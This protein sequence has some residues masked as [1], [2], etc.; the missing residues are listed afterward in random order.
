[1]KKLILLL[2]T[3]TYASTNAWPSLSWPTM[4]FAN[5]LPTFNF[6]RNGQGLTQ[7][8][9]QYSDIV[10]FTLPVMAFGSVCLYEDIKK[11]EPNPSLTTI[12]SVFATCYGAEVFCRFMHELGHCVTARALF[13]EMTT[14]HPS[15]L[16]VS[17]LPCGHGSFGIDAPP[18]PAEV[19]SNKFLKAITNFYDSLFIHSSSS[20]TASSKSI[21]ESSTFLMKYS[22][23]AIAGPLMS[24]CAAW[25]C[26]RA[27]KWCK[28]ENIKTAMQ[29][30]AISSFTFGTVLSLVGGSDGAQIYNCLTKLMQSKSN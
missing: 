24:A 23:V 21:E 17:L 19:V 2:L 3:A 9:I 12:G 28:N 8:I 11:N 25:G 1:M 4:K 7:E 22:T 6:T 10:P 20:T 13:P 26:W 27:S 16:Y 14:T 30:A 5:D 29:Y 18:K 15:H